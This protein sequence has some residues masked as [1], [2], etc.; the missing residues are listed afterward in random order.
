MMA[1]T[2]TQVT[3]VARINVVWLDTVRGLST[4]AIV[5]TLLFAGSSATLWIT[6]AAPPIGSDDGR[7]R[8]TCASS[9]RSCPAS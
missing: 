2:G 6:R 9:D 4:L 8:I 5:F 7:C 3:A 1:L